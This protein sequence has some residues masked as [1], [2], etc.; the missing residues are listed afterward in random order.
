MLRV[1]AVDV[2]D[3]FPCVGHWSFLQELHQRVGERKA[4]MVMRIMM[5]C[6]D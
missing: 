3:A 2:S 6:A 1:R 4:Y 5:Q